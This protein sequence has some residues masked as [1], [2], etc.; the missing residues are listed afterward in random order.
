[1]RSRTGLLAALLVGGIACSDTKP[2][3]QGTLMIT[4]TFEAEAIR[5]EKRGPET[6]ASSAERA[7]SVAFATSAGSV[8]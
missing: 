2:C 6:G 3:K 4:A 8:G 1:M 7:A 5:S